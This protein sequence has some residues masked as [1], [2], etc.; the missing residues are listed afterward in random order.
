MEIG[1]IY[2]ISIQS[3]KDGEPKY[4]LC[5]CVKNRFV[6]LINTDPRKKKT[7]ARKNKKMN[8]DVVLPQTS[9]KFPK[10]RCYINCKNI[11]KIERR[12]N[13]D[14]VGKINTD[15]ANSVIDKIKKNQTISEE[16]KEMIISC[17]EE[18]IEN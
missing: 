2:K 17:L 10:Y 13:Y 18:Y 12:K 11:L 16:N 3:I 4:C 9:E 8:F 5:V 15:Q 14:C 6:L 7:T 1:H